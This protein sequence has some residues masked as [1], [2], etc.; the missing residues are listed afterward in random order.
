MRSLLLPGGV[1]AVVW[2]RGEDSGGTLTM[3]T[4]SAPPGWRLPLHRH[5]R[6]SETI[7]ITAG[8]SFMVIDGER[9]ELAAGDTVHIPAGVRHEGGTLGVDPV[10]RIVVFAPSG[11]ETFFEALALEREPAA[12][13]DLAI[14]HG[15]DFA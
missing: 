14:R 10:E 6:E 1:E 5:R 12:M 13:L 4:D 15:W 11:M 3:L 2:V 9:C 7:H 8:R